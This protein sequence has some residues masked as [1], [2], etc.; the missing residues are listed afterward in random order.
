MG[1]FKFHECGWLLDCTIRISLLV[2]DFTVLK[3]AVHIAILISTCKADIIILTLVVTFG[4]TPHATC[5]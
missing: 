1:G 3:Q 2:V 5:H 4:T